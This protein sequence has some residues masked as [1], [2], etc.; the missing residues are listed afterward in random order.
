MRKLIREF[1]VRYKFRNIR[2]KHIG[3][4]SQV[5]SL[6]SKFSYAD[7]ISIGNDVW[8]GPHCELDGYGGINISDGVI[9]APGVIVY[10]RS[11]NFNSKDLKSLPFDDRVITGEVSIG[12]YSWIGRNVI[13]LPGVTIGEGA[14]V[15]AGAVI[16][17][18]VEPLSVVVGN[19]AKKIRSRDPLVYGVLARE[20]KF[21]YTHLGHGKQEMEPTDV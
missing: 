15:G 3:A 11:H 17:K 2:F 14:V 9:F 20:G 21:V 6:Y 16:A 4:R 1:L 19:P 7:R 5:L 13:I 8:L 10:S 18:D 12:R